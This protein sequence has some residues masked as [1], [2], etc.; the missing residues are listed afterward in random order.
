MNFQFKWDILSYLGFKIPIWVP[1]WVVKGLNF[2]LF[3]SNVISN[4]NKE[5]RTGWFGQLSTDFT[6]E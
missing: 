4:P 6:R 5:Q 3:I 2:S 1:H